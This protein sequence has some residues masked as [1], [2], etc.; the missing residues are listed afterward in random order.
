VV[1]QHA[2]LAS[3]G[4]PAG[5]ACVNIYLFPDGRDWCLRGF[6]ATLKTASE[7]PIFSLSQALQS[8]LLFPFLSH[9]AKAPVL[10]RIFINTVFSRRDALDTRRWIG[11][12]SYYIMVVTAMGIIAHDF[13]DFYHRYCSDV[14]KVKTGSLIQDEVQISGYHC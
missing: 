12:K 5:Y 7:S 13:F 2:L 8:S 1:G 4:C 10:M 3:P 14:A 6:V 9:R 11:V